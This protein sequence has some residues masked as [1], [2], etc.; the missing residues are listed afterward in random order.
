MEKIKT[1]KVILVEGKYDKIKLESFIVGTIITTNG[2]SVFN[3]REKCV[4]LRKISE[5]R[6]IVILTDSDGAGFLIR[7]KLKGIIGCSG[8]ITNIYSPQILGKEQRKTKSSK[9][10]FLGVEGI[11]VDILRE[12][13]KKAGIGTEDDREDFC[14]QRYTKSDLYEMGYSGKDN[15]ALLRDEK[16]REND[17]PLSMSANAFLEA[18]NL[19]KIEL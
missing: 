8:K 17:L 15:S 16:C 12:L 19:L 3:D 9:Q 1:D 11:N 4:L 10:G 2:F 7:N 13:F 5:N 14:E 6:G 18:V